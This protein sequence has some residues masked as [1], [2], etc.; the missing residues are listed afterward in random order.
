MKKYLQIIITILLFI[1][2]SNLTWY[3]FTDYHKGQKIQTALDND[4]HNLQIHYDIQQYYQRLTADTTYMSTILMP[5][6]IE[7]LSKIKDATKEQKDVLRVEL[8]N[9]LIPKYEIIKQKGI[10][11]YHFVLPNNESFLRMHKPEKFGDNLKDIRRGFAYTNTKKIVSRGFSHGKTKH[12]FR[13]VYPIFDDKGKYLCAVEISYL[14]NSIQEQLSTLSKIHSHFLVN[15]KDYLKYGFTGSDKAYKQ[16][17]EHK[18]FIVTLDVE[19]EDTCVARGKLRLDSIKDKIAV[20]MNKH[21]KFSLYVNCE[22]ESIV[23]AFIP[24]KSILENKTIAWLVSYQLDTNIDD[25]ILYA[26]N[27]RLL[28]FLIS[29]LVS[30][31]L[32]LNLVSQQQI[33]L[34]AY[35]DGLTNIYNRY[36]FEEIAESELNR[37]IRYR[38]DLSIAILDID[39]FKIFNDTHGHLVGDEVLVMLA[40]HIDSNVRDIDTFARWGGEEFVILFPE[41]SLENAKKVCEKLRFSVSKLEHPKAGSVTVSFGLTQYTATD[42]LITL[43]E[44]C[45][46]ALYKAKENGRNVVSTN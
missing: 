4:L 37:D 28:F 40:Q 20:N 41:T 24:I 3:Y 43:F 2:S 42:D 1:I 16:S 46:Q 39:N 36:K 5:K 34:K 21:N 18:D 22:G 9:F 45:D 32:F 12:G 23:L 44:R 11:Q 19:H 29:V 33:K 13:N 27:I 25:I 14:N 38:R 35:T 10:Y 15:K 7:I 30:Y 31:L 6:V 17:N 8:Q 26:S